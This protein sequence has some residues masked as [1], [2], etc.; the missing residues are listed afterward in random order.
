MIASGL[1]ISPI[2]SSLMFSQ[3]LRVGAPPQVRRNPNVQLKRDDF[4]LTTAND[5]A[6]FLRPPYPPRINRTLPAAASGRAKKNPWP[7]TVHKD[8]KLRLVTVIT[9]S[10]ANMSTSAEEVEEHRVC[11]RA[12]A[13]AQAQRRLPEPM[14]RPCFTH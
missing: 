7:T 12:R 11:A 10:E 8:Y 6:Y 1:L 5:G 13:Y 4:S 3:G 14:G 9:E 2:S